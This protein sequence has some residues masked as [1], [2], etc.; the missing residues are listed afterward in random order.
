[1]PHQ[2]ATWPVY[3]G[4]EGPNSLSFQSIFILLCANTSLIAPQW[5]YTYL[6]S[7]LTWSPI[8][9]TPVP[10]S[11]P[12]LLHP[13]ADSCHSYRYSLASVPIAYMSMQPCGSIL[14]K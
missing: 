10:C 9:C 4:P 5:L 7:F 13:H 1:M 14:Y 8:V 12:C 2:Q 11:H 6:F 3:L